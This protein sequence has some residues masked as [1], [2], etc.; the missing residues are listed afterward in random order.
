ML[1]IDLDDFMIELEGGTVKHVGAPTAAATVKMYHVSDAE[2]RAFGDSQV[3]LTFDD[4]EGNH[5]EVALDSADAAA[6]ASTLD[7][8]DEDNAPCE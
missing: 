7:R 1:T 5:V 6:V 2:A 4:D 8:L 3:K